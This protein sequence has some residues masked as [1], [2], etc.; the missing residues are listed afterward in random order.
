MPA[1]PTCASTHTVK[2]GR[3]HNGKQRFKC[4]G[5]GRQ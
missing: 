2:N 1:C 3:I 5:C 4:H